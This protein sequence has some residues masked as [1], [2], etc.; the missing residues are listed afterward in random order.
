MRDPTPYE[1]PHRYGA[2]MGRGTTAASLRTSPDAVKVSLR[3]IR[4]NGGG[5][6]RGGAYWGAGVPLW[7]AGSDCGL[8]DLY[9]R[10]ADRIAAKAHVRQQFP[11]AAFYR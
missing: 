8:V 7:W 10:A 6:D 2:P 5:Y 4:L 3:R 9:F 11:G 1:G